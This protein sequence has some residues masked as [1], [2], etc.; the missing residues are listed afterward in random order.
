MCCLQVINL[1]C[2]SIPLNFLCRW[3]PILNSIGACRYFLHVLQINQ[4]IRTFPLFL[5]I[6]C[7]P[8]AESGMFKKDLFKDWG[9]NHLPYCGWYMDY[10][11]DINIELKHE[12]R[13]RFGE[14]NLEK[15]TLIYLSLRGVKHSQSVKRVWKSKKQSVGPSSENPDI[16]DFVE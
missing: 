1:I 14:T 10:P 13:E 4:A 15:A 11:Y 9:P 8:K 3:I 5:R 6:W 2:A 12:L 16:K 7:D